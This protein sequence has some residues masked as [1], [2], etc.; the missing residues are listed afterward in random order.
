MTATDLRL[1]VDE[2]RRLTAR[3]RELEADLVAVGSR[4]SADVV[5]VRRQMEERVAAL[6]QQRAD[7]YVAHLVSC[8]FKIACESVQDNV[9]VWWYSLFQRGGGHGEWR[10]AI[11]ETS[12]I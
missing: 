6:E 9:V 3:V 10:R 7:A 12:A 2:N 4:S 5:S 8:V 1:A 11:L